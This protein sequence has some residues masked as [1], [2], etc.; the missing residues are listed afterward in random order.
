MEGGFYSEERGKR[1]C[2]FPRAPIP[3]TQILHPGAGSS[4]EKKSIS[5]NENAGLFCGVVKP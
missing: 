3:E 2:P 5:A 4:V 1:R